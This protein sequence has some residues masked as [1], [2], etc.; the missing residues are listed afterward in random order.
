MII[1]NPDD[2]NVTSS[3]ESREVDVP[4]VVRP[5]EVQLG[6]D[7]N[8]HGVYTQLS[9]Y[10]GPIPPPELLKGYDD[11][12]PGAAETILSQF[13]KQGDHRMR[14]EEQEMNLAQIVVKTDS[15]KSLHGLYIGGFL[16]FILI[17]G[18][19]YLL[20]M[21]KTLEGLVPLIGVLG[22]LVG[23][24]LYTRSRTDDTDDKE[25]PENTQGIQNPE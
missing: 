24:F 25:E 5:E 22:T 23:V 9:T 16:A 18:A 15:R 21:G 10:S 20:Y 7:K 2:E 6:N 12:L 19:L 13:V 14:L 1:D 11:V 3:E 4:D 8:K 17:I